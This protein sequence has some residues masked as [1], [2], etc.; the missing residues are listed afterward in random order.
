MKMQYHLIK[1]ALQI[2]EK[3]H[4]LLSGIGTNQQP[5]R[6]AQCWILT[7]YNKVN[8]IASKDLSMENKI[9]MLDEVM[10]EIFKYPYNR[11]SFSKYE[12]PQE[13]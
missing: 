1:V 4:D 8:S 5:S 3:Q 12:K 13:L 6:K 2:S 10:G 11:E 7:S 9:I